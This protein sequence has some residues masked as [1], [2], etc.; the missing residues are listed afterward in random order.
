MYT[1]HAILILVP[2]RVCFFFNWTKWSESFQKRTECLK[3]LIK[4]W[5]MNIEVGQF[6]LAIKAYCKSLN[7]TRTWWWGAMSKK[8][9]STQTRWKK[10]NVENKRSRSL[11]H[12]SDILGICVW[13]LQL[14]I[15]N[16]QIRFLAPFLLLKLQSRILNSW[17]KKLK[18]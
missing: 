17:V 14:W 8:E 4:L 12:W 13:C 3:Y 7:Q 11:L 5:K 9:I 1:F 16:S 2:V 15:L 6:L 18:V 10:L